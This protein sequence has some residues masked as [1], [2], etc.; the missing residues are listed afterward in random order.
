MAG[1]SQLRV[2]GS[3][4]GVF[5]LE[6]ALAAV[7]AMDLPDAGARAR[8]LLRLIKEHNYV[9]P[10]AEPAYLAAL[11]REYRVYTGQAEPD[12]GAG[13]VVLGRGC[14]LCRALAEQVLQVLARAGLAVEVLHQIDPEASRRYGAAALPALVINGQVVVAGRVP[15]PAE[16]QRLLLERLH[17]EQ[18]PQ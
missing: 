9:P 4:V 13:V 7:K 6:A 12:S 2:G 18:E 14:T 15:P 5:G 16:L 11:E 1:I 8:E 10:G 3:R 17:S